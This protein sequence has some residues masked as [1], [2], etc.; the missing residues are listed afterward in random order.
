VSDTSGT[1]KKL[2]G[3]PVST[4]RTSEEAENLLRAVGAGDTRALETLYDAYLPLVFGIASRMIGP[5]D[6]SIEAA[7]GATFVAAWHAAP[8]YREGHVGAWLGRITRNVAS[9]ALGRETS[10]SYEPLAASELDES[11]EPFLGKLDGTAIRAALATLPPS[12]RMLL[13][14]GFFERLGLV[15]MGEEAGVPAGSVKS[16]IRSGLTKFR[17]VLQDPLSA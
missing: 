9:R 15:R 4:R 8:A 10:L 12:E 14:M 5:S 7:V 6:R 3:A 13:E 17:A 2:L 11:V 1:A 16:L